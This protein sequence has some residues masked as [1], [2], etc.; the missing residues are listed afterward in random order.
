[1]RFGAIFSPV[2][3][4]GLLVVVARGV[5]APVARFAEERSVCQN[6]INNIC[7]QITVQAN[8]NADISVIVAHFAQLTARLNIILSACVTIILQIFVTICASLKLCLPIYVS[9]SAWTFGAAA[10]VAIFLNIPLGL[11]A[12]LVLFD[13]AFLTACTSAD[14]VLLAAVGLSLSGLST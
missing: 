9:V 10:I 13:A 3:S 12:K 11:C 6:E 8:A 7:G 14:L 5:V 1:M 2:L 4:F